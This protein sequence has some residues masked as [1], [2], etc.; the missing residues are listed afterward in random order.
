[1]NR[2]KKELFNKIESIEDNLYPLL[3]QLNDF[4]DCHLVGDDYNKTNE[5]VVKMKEVVK[6]LHNIK[7][8]SL[9]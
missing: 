7:K 9:A 3:G 2:Y 1:M 5:T 6:M 8:E 4:I